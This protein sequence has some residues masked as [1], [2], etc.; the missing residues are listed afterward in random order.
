MVWCDSKPLRPFATAIDNS[1][2]RRR[3][4]RRAQQLRTIAPVGPDLR[5]ANSLRACNKTQAGTRVVGEHPI[6]SGTSTA[7]SSGTKAVTDGRMKSTPVAVTNVACT[8]GAMFPAMSRT[9]STETTYDAVAARSPLGVSVSVRLPSERVVVMGTGSPFPVSVTA[10]RLVGWMGSSNRTWICTLRGTAVAPVARIGEEHGRRRRVG[11]EG[12]D[13]AAD[14][15]ARPVAG[16]VPDGDVHRL[17]AAH[18]AGL[19]RFFSPAQTQ[20][21]RGTPQI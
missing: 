7:P 2:R 13:E 18:M 8:A 21:H 20:I 15:P 10:S 6:T 16:Q 5:F 1:F 17:R 9:P 3:L 4:A 11:G 19:H 14:K 12:G